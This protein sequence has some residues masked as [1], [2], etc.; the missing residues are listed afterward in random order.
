MP[1]LSRRVA[2]DH[3]T[4][5]AAKLVLVPRY[6]RL[7]ERDRRRR[8]PQ[9]VGADQQTIRLE[10]AKRLTV[11]PTDITITRQHLERGHELL[12][13]PPAVRLHSRGQLPGDRERGVERLGGGGRPAGLPPPG[14]AAA[15][16]PPP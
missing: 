5:H 13:A 14:A 6:Q 3:Q 7:A 4:R 2:Q 12:P 8:D 11:L 16:P 10:V 15:P 9:V 1:R